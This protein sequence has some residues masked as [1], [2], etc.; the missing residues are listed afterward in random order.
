MTVMCIEFTISPT[1]SF[2]ISYVS[3]AF[4]ILLIG[5]REHRLTAMTGQL[6]I[7]GCYASPLDAYSSGHLLLDA[8]VEPA[9][10]VVPVSYEHLTWTCEL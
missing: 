4:P 1:S 5:R 7:D 6:I 2:L 9:R 8:R 10:Q 3:L